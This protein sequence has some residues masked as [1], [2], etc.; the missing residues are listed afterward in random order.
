MVLAPQTGHEAAQRSLIAADP[1]SATVSEVA[2]RY[3]FF[4]FGRFARDY[5]K[6]FHEKPS[7]TLKR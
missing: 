5:Q 4:N 1:H 2:T 7:D 3:G 6:A